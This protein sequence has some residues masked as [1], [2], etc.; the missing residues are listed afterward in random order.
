M[1]VTIT[2]ADDAV[3]PRELRKLSDAYPFVEWALL[4]SKKRAG[5]P[6]YPS[7][8]GFK[9]ACNTLYDKRLAAHLCGS[10]ARLVM[11]RCDL[12]M[13][14]PPFAGRVQL[15]GYEPNPTALARFEHVQ[16]WKRCAFILQARSPDGFFA[17]ARDARLCGASVLYDPSGGRGQAAPWPAAP[18]GVRFGYAGGINAENVVMALNEADDRGASWIDM[19][20]G[21]RDEQDRF[22]LERVREV[23]ARAAEWMG[24]NRG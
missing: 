11:E 18:P 16:L 7:E 9:N 17:C 21:V 12:E 14:M 20:S 4:W 10:Y 19:E 5:G 2:G 24:A 8:A 15:N 23:L 13:V 3:D 6:R 22:D 1:I